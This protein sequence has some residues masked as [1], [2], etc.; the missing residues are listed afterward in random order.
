VAGRLGVR[1]TGLAG[2]LDL[3]RGRIDG[4][5]A[6]LEGRLVWRAWERLLENEFID[7]SVALAAKAF[8]ALFPLTI[9]VSAF[10]PQGVRREIGDLT[11]TRF[12]LSGSART[13]VIDAFARPD[14]TRAATGV[15]GLIFL[16]FYATTFTTALQKV[17]LKAWRRPSAGGVPAARGMLWLAG[18]IVV[19]GLL[20]TVRNL[21]GRGPQSAFGLVVWTAAAIAGWWVTSWL[22]LRGEVRWRA[23]AASAVVTGIAMIGYS[24]TTSLWMPRTV[25]QNQA[26]FGVF[27]VTLALVS[28]F[29]G[30]GFVLV[31][32]TVLG[33]VL[34]EEP[35]TVGRLARG[36]TAGA[37]RPGAAPSLAPP[38]RP[39]GVADALV[40]RGTED[41]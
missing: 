28:W 9:A 16:F 36:G 2:R 26:Q 24:V 14:Q 38:T 19:A 40:A 6:R 39:L 34:A 23:L 1:R 3:L 32:A 22:M 11:Q 41:T 4:V 8:I 5:R 27:G 12:G 35:G 18:L 37:L 30:L 17:Y 13:M 21:L 31:I 33:V 15:F 7:R 25:E 10:A 20:D 29:V